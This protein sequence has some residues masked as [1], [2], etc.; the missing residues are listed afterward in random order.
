[1]RAAIFALVSMAVLAS[2]PAFA[3]IVSGTVRV[4]GGAA[5]GRGVSGD[6]KDSS[7]S[8]G[9]EGAT[10][11]ARVGVEVFFINLWVGHDQYVGSDGLVGTWTT[12]PMIGFDTEFDVGSGGAP[13]QG[14][15]GKVVPGAPDWFVHMAFGAGFGVGTGQQIDPPLDNAE[16]TD[17]GFLFEGEVGLARK[18]GSALSIGIAVPVQYRFMFKNGADAAANSPSDRYQSVA[19]SALLNLRF[20]L[21]LF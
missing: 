18:L 11:G 9:A 3:D 16:I 6:L 13:T 2:S 8:E 15:N 17:K 20:K 4:H 10:Y 21:R 14:A 5:S 12:L 7:F 19:A 1:M